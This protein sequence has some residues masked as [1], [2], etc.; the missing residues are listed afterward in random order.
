MDINTFS[1]KLLHELSHL[2]FFDKVDFHL[3]IITI[4][5]RVFLKEEAYFFEIY[6][7]SKK[8]TTAFA[9]IK[10]DKRIWGIDYD[11][12]RGWYEHPLDNPITHKQI[13]S[14]SIPEVLKEFEKVYTGLQSQK[15]KIFL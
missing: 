15:S 6:Y 3:E 1:N 12:I 8:E 4:K 11:N 2:Y 9:L 5:G 10:N 14:M 13:H 7:N